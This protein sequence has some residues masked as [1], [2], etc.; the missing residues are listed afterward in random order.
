VYLRIPLALALTLAASG[1]TAA[2]DQPRK[3]KA[4]TK[5]E[6]VLPTHLETGTFGRLYRLF[7]YR[8]LSLTSEDGVS[9]ASLSLIRIVV[10]GDHAPYEL[11]LNVRIIAPLAR[12]QAFLPVV[13]LP[14]GKAVA[15]YPMSVGCSTDDATFFAEVPI[16]PDDFARTVT[17]PT[18]D[19]SAIPFDPC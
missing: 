5:A 15:V 10:T 14:D 6:A 8:D 19:F 7:D 13:T 17:H 1:T 9:L 3:V 4:A 11:L 12:S 16:T 18:I 2:P